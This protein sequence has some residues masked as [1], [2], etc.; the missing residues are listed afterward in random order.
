MTETFNAIVYVN[1]AM[2]AGFTRSEAEFQAQSIIHMTGQLVTKG[3]LKEVLS[4]EFKLFEQK[5]TIKLGVMLLGMV[6]LLTFLLK[7]V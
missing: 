1:E 2:V 4:N 5:I 6:G 7:H 3:Y